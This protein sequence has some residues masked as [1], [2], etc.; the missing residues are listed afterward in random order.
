MQR[1]KCK[2]IVGTLQGIFNYFVLV[3]LSFTSFACFIASVFYMHTIVVNKD[4]YIIKL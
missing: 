4:E 1:K 2:D 3:P